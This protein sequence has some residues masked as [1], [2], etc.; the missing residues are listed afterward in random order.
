MSA[1]TENHALYTLPILVDVN[2]KTSY[3]SPAIN[4]RISLPDV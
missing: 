4:H 2:V 3:D 1:S